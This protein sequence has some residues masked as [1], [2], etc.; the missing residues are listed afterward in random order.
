MKKS[1]LILTVL[2]CSVCLSAQQ[3]DNATTKALDA[4]VMSRMSI[5]HNP[6]DPV[7]L[8]KVFSGN[9]YEVNLGFSSVDGSILTGSDYYL[10]VTDGKVTELPTLSTDME[11]TAM[12]SLLKKD[13]VIK[14]EA[15]AAAF[16]KSLDVLFPLRES[17]R[18][19][20]KHMKKSTQWI[21]IR[22]KFFDDNTAVIVTTNPDGTV[23]KIEVKLAYPAAS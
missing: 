5:D 7:T 4:Y 10:N 23:S 8:G 1:F 9:F 15:G 6:L 22:G 13:F 20:V 12:F 18:S 11:L 14:D 21:F 3:P 19:N 2:T 16:E 17:E